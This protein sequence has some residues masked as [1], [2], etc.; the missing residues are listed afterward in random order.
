[1][2]FKLLTNTFFVYRDFF[3][4]Q[5]LFFMEPVVS[6]T[7]TGSFHSGILEED[8]ILDKQVDQRARDCSPYRAMTEDGVANQIS[9]LTSQQGIAS[10]LAMT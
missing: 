9:R 10:C 2:E 5:L 8:G 4:G 7:C 6:L 1:M 3:V